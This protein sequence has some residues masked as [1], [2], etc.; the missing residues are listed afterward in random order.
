MT[1]RRLRNVKK[2]LAREREG[3]GMLRYAQHDKG[4]VQHKRIPSSGL[5]DPL[6]SPAE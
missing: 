3:A 6:E 4:G 5:V 1:G 2:A